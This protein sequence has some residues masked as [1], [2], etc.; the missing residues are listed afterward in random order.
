VYV[1][2]P[3]L[4]LGGDRAEQLLKFGARAGRDGCAGPAARRTVCVLGGAPTEHDP[5]RGEGCGRIYQ[6]FGYGAGHCS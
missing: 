1:T 4:G 2:L 5:R 6:L 3:V